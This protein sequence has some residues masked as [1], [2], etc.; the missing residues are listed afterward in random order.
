ME[1]IFDKN[2]VQHLLNITQTHREQINMHISEQ[3]KTKQKM[4]PLAWGK[5]IAV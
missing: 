5:S 3:N 2:V 4:I 1:L